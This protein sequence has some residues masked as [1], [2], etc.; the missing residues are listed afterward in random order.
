[1]GRAHVWFDG[2]LPP[3]CRANSENRGLLHPLW[4]AVVGLVGVCQSPA[5]ARNLPTR[6]RAQRPNMNLAQS[7]GGFIEILLRDLVHSSL[8]ASPPPSKWNWGRGGTPG[9]PFRVPFFVWGK[10][11]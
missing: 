4:E 8:L 2:A 1:M 6:D 7:C 5:V 10:T 3:W 9:I 11:E